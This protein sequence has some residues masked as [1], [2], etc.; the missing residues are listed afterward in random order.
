MPGARLW[1]ERGKVGFEKFVGKSFKMIFEF[2]PQK[3][4][5][6]GKKLKKVKKIRMGGKCVGKHLKKSGRVENVRESEK[7]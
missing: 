6:V 1:F 4:K 5:S 7:K 3:V 2:F